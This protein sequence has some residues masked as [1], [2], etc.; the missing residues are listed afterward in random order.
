MPAASA[1]LTLRNVRVLEQDGG[2]SGEI[3]VVVEEGVVAGVGS[4]LATPEGAPQYDLRGLWLMP[5]M[6]DCHVHVAVSTMDE[7]QVLRNPVSYGVLEAAVNLRKTLEAGVTHLRD[8]GGADA[9]MKRAVAEGLVPGPR[10]QLSIK[11]LSQTG[12]HGDMYSERL[13]IEPDPLFRDMLTTV[14]GVEG[15]RV[16]V[17]RMLRAGAD[18]IKLCTSGGVMTP[19]D[20]PYD[21]G[22]TVEEVAVAVAEAARREK[23]V[24]THAHGGEGIDMAVAA[25]VRSIEHGTL[26]TERQAA[27]M[28]KAGCWLVPTLTII[29]DLIDSTVPAEGQKPLAPPYALRKVLEL[30]DRFGESVRIA[31]AAGVR[32]AAGTDF[33]ERRQHGRNLEEIALLHE[34][35]MPLEEA[36]LAATSRGA[37]LCGVE[38][39]YGRIAPGYVFD[40][41]VLGEDPSDASVFKRPAAVLEVF[42]GGAPCKTGSELLRERGPAQRAVVE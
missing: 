37:E 16:A 14:D 20:T 13:G 31:R 6:V 26:L 29:K 22:F 32:I 3:D 30:Q 34:A 23:P 36:L 28:A 17:R 19:H 35:G 42:K 24:M 18:W 1:T 10:L 5:G 39:L 33:I 15:M 12:G 11:L 4:G 7:H 27:A 21:S 25:G 38:H 8:A 9:G 41:L 40:A 2:F